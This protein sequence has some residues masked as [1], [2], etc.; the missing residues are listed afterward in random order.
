MGRYLPSRE[1]GPDRP[2]HTGCFDGP[3]R[4]DRI[5]PMHVQPSDPVVPREPRTA[6]PS[7]R[8]RFRAPPR[9]RAFG[10]HLA[11]SSVAAAAAFAA[12]R[13]GLPGGPLPIDG[14]SR[15]AAIV[16]VAG[17]VLGPALTL[18]LYRP[19]SAGRAL[20]LGLIATLQ[21]AAL[22][23]AGLVAHQQ[24]T[25][26]V[27]YADGAFNALTARA[28]ERARARLEA[29]GRLEDGARPLA[30]LESGAGLP[31]VFVPPPAPGELGEH[32]ERLLDG[33]PEPHERSDRYVA[34]APSAAR[35]APDP[36][37]ET[38]LDLDSIEAPAVRAAVG[39]ALDEAGLA[40]ERVQ[41]HRFRAHRASGIAIY[42]PASVRILDRVTA[43]SVE[44][45][46]S[47]DRAHPARG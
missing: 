13:D 34:L 42:D 5:P 7:R 18:L 21:G 1:V 3:T 12:L 32:L 9:A 17:L 29:L 43:G 38:A 2:G 11:L 6:P 10:L 23:H 37:A 24:R 44:E 47:I 30:T 36:L 40:A 4:R 16:A 39:R 26:A 45:A 28:Y 35:G 33:W 8:G 27:V 14:D 19:G 15:A 41:L 25:V 46:V 22:G 20:V 31:L